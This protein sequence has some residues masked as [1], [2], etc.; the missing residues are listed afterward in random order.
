MAESQPLDSL[1]LALMQEVL[2]MGLAFVDRVR[3]DGP[4]KAVESVARG[5]DPLGDLRQQGEAAAREV[6]ERLDQISPGLGNPVVSVQV[7]VDDPMEPQVQLDS[8]QGD[9][10]Q[11]QDVLE[12]IDGR[13]Q[14]LDALMNKVS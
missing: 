12:R 14:R 13:L 9:S 11:L 4:A 3:S 1:R 5:N 6:R 2:P 10:L 8:D 7:E